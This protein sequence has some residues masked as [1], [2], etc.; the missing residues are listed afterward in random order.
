M[1]KM[2]GMSV[3]KDREGKELEDKVVNMIVETAADI[4]KESV[5]ILLIDKYFVLSIGYYSQDLKIV[6]GKLMSKIDIFF[7]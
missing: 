6:E 3:L 4:I 5:S 7:V 2:W 1:Q